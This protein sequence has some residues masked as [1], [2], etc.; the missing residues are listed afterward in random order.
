MDDIERKKYLAEIEKETSTVGIDMPDN[1]EVNG[2]NIPAND[3]IFNMSSEGNLP[4]NMDMKI[5]QLKQDLIKEKNNLIE[6][7]EKADITSDTAEEYI[8][9]INQVERVIDSLNPDDMSFGDKSDI[10]E[11]KKTK[12]WRDFIDK[13]RDS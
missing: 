1:L 13:I 7:I 2:N 8:E 12:K 4:G 3:I 5:S 9:K 11:A 10:N 6:E